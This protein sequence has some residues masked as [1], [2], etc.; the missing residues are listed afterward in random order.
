MKMKSKKGFVKFV[1]VFAAIVL[2]AVLFT[3]IKAMGQESSEIIRMSNIEPNKV[4]IDFNSFLSVENT[5]RTYIEKMSGVPD[6]ATDIN[7][8]LK[9]TFPNMTSARV[10]SGGDPNM[11]VLLPMGE[12]TSMGFGYG[13]CFETNE[14]NLHINC[15]QWC[16]TEL[17]AE[18]GGMHCFDSGSGK[19]GNVIYKAWKNPLDHPT[20]EIRVVGDGCNEKVWRPW[21]DL[22]RY[23]GCDLNYNVRCSCEVK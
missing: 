20:C 5:R 6:T 18:C 2:G 13:G 4:V 19:S 21:N 7:N 8:T 16:K 10:V 23:G 22:Y 17:N 12:K 3:T 11:T 9:K 14:G 1:A 15:S